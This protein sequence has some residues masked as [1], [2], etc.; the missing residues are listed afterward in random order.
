MSDK[1]NIHKSANPFEKSENLKTWFQSDVEY[2]QFKKE[3]K[4]YLVKE[5]FKSF[6]NKRS[7]FYHRF[8]AML[9]NVK[10]WF[11][12]KNNKFKWRFLVPAVA[13]VI[14]LILTFSWFNLGSDKYTQMTWETG[15]NDGGELWK[16]DQ[17]SKE[18]TDFLQNAINGKSLQPSNSFSDQAGRE[19]LGFSVD[20][21]K[22]VNNFRQNIE[23]GFMPQVTD[24]TTEG[25]FYDYEFQTDYGQECQNLFCPGFAGVSSQNPLTNQTEQFLAIGLQSNLKQSDFTRPNLNLTVV[26]DISSSMNSPFN[27]YYY[28]NQNF[29]N[30]QNQVWKYEE[31]EQEIEISNKTKIEIA[32]ASISKMTK[33]LRAEDR[34]SV[35]VFDDEAEV[36]M[37]FETVGETDM[38][39]I[40]EK[41]MKIKTNGGT[42]MGTGI[43][44]A[45]KLYEDL[46]ETE[47]GNGNQ[48]RI[49]FFTDAMPNQGELSENGLYRK[50]KALSQ[51]EKPVYTTFVGVGID[52][53]SNLTEKISKVQGANY[54]TIRSEKEFQEEIAENFDYLV[55]PLVFDL[56]M[57]FTSKDLKI[58]DTFGIPEQFEKSDYEDLEIIKINTLFP[59]KTSKNGS[60]GGIILLKLK[61]ISED[62]SPKFQID[63][64]YKDKFQKEY[65]EKIETEFITFDLD[66]GWVE[67]TMTAEVSK[68][69][70]SIQK[71]ILLSRYAELL[72]NWI[73]EVRTEENSEN[74]EQASLPL[75]I[76][77]EKK[78]EF[79]IFKQHFDG[80]VEVIGD[81]ELER[82][83]EVF[84]KVLELP[85]RSD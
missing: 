75:Q 45:S 32:T 54:L 26:F 3:V 27:K 55:T 61:N 34:L 58:L 42:N 53:N 18:Q 60:K 40:R 25:L 82:E 57:N 50:I 11:E 52:H 12:L 44:A 5:N 46:F 6:K 77:S 14:I 7:S 22:D 48:N 71:G 2:H 19:N 20:G 78:N 31:N 76:S 35:V 38:D 83:K 80:Q 24:V 37:D 13:S 51:Q 81:V 66:K 67:S 59:S 64:K 8:L 43:D 33:N 29:N 62:N 73:Q 85:D 56:K 17:K 9:A 49:L 84:D 16:L 72:Q 28:D 30:S 79:S 47:T 15:K 4:K 70:T 65:F 39:F 1:K 69:F 36:A 74:L 41:I 10:T 68:S 23:N 63:F 21:S